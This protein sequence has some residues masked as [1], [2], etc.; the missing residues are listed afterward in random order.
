MVVI[1][2]VVVGNWV[3][4]PLLTCVSP[5]SSGSASFYPKIYL[6]LYISTLQ[7]TSD[8][9]EESIRY[10]YR[11]LWATLWLQCG[12]WDLN[13]GPLV[14]AHIRWAISP[15]LFSIAL[16]KGLMAKSTTYVIKCQKWIWGWWDGSVGKSTRLLFRRS[17]VQ[18]PA[19]SWWLTTIC[20]KIWLPLLEC[21]KTATVYLHIINNSLKKM[22]LLAN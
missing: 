19:T 22:D 1:F 8:A 13:S 3:L 9:P 18:I 16:Q 14:S 20:N 7:L 11:C 6:L 2:H 5:A 4:G 12:Y 10:H 15:A 21:L 17:G